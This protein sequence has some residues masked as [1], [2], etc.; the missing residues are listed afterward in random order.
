MKMRSPRGFGAALVLLLGVAMA[1][2][3][4]NVFGTGAED[5]LHL[6]LGASFLLLAFAVFDFELPRW[7]RLA[8]SAATGVLAGVF[9]LQGASDLLHS[10]PLR[11]LAYD[12][13]GS[14]WRRCS[15]TRFC[16]GA[17]ACSRWTPAARRRF[18]APRCW[19]LKRDTR[20]AAAA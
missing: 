4:D 14:A 2:L 13:W 11:R 10:E 6:A 19:R 16:S 15:A 7:I 17:S 3:T 5:V 8:A 9:L 20:R 18:S 1:V 12:S